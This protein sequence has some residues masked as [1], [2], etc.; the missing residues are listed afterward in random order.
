MSTPSRDDRQ[1]NI[2]RTCL[3]RDFE[4]FLDATV[5]RHP[6]PAQVTANLATRSLAALIARDRVDSDSERAASMLTDGGQDFGIDAIA[7]GTGAPRSISGRMT[8]STRNC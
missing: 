3:L 4:P 5:F 1:I 6:D 2:I 8:A 7:I